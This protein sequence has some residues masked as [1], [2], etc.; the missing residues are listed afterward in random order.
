MSLVLA[1]LVCFL[2]FPLYSVHQQEL[3][4]VGTGD[5]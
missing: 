2:F 5:E 4:V 3:I 1:F